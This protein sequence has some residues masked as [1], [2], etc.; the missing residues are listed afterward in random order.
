MIKPKEMSKIKHEIMLLSLLLLLFGELLIPK[1]YQSAVQPLLFIQTIF[2]GIILFS[3]KRMW[4][5]TF[6]V[7]FGIA[8]SLHIYGYF[9]ESKIVDTVS[10]VIYLIFFLSVSLET[11]RQIY[12]AKEVGAA[13]IA[14]VFS[15]F[16]LLCLMASMFFMVVE[17][18]SP[19]SFSNI[20]T[21]S[22]RFQNLSYFSFITTLTIGYGDITPLTLH[23]KKATMF[24]ALLG[25]FYTVFVTG[26]VIGKY[27]NRKS[28]N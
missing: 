12:A 3:E 24:I 21:D 2:A 5:N 28:E 15:G 26:I 20:G 11:Y 19:N 4:R 10:G 25:N 23:A 8:L 17:I 14:A 27:L 16:I 22:E 13:M 1:A 6:L 18:Q 7:L 9:Y